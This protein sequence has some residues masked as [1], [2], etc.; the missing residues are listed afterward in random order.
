MKEKTLFRKITV[1]VI[2]LVVF[3]PFIP[4]LIWSCSLRWTFPSLVPEWSM[5]AW[6]YVFSQ[7]AI[8]Q[9]L[10]TSIWTSFAVTFFAL[11]IGLPAARALGTMRFKGKK[12]AETLVTLPAIVPTLAVVMGLQ[13]IFIKIGLTNTY[14]GV[15]IV[16]LIPTLPYMIMYLQSTFMDYNTDYE[17][18]ARVLGANSTITFFKVTMPIIWPGVIVA[19]LY[20]FLV[21]WSQY[22][23]TVVIGGAKVKTLPTILFAYLGSGDNAMSAA[24]SLVFILPAILILILTSKYL[25]G[26]KK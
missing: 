15:I 11:V 23:L 12:F 16:Q 7:S 18:C 26:S 2:F 10:Y 3:G 24:V 20:S 9:G 19:S 22:L 8:I 21:A 13:V 1:A 5:R 4:L 14:T 6:N 25:S 17:D